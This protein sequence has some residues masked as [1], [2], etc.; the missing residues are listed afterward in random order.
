MLTGLKKSGPFPGDEMESIS[1]KPC[2]MKFQST[3]KNNKRGLQTREVINKCPEQEVIEL[4]M[5]PRS[6]AWASWR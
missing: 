5:A 2:G 3:G 4:R 6:L 1:L